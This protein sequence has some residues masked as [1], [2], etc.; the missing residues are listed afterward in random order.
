M[1]IEDT[2]LAK[3]R[4]RGLTKG[5]ELLLARPDALEFIDDCERLGLAIL[6]LDFYKAQ[7]GDIIETAAP[8]DYSSLNDL[9]D[10]AAQST[11]AARD[12]IRHGLPDGA[13][14]VSFVVD[15]E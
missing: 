2:V 10:R 13:R 15:D 1:A 9:P 11:E 14:W 3:Y 4:T 7:G 8:A 12:L 6:G 5:G